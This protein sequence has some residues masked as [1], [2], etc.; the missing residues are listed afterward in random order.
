MCALGSGDGRHCW[1][2]GYGEELLQAPGPR[3]PPCLGHGE[4]AGR[5]RP[6]R[7][8][9]TR[10]EISPTPKHCKPSPGLSTCKKGLRAQR[11]QGLK[12]LCVCVCV[13]V[14]CWVGVSFSAFRDPI[15]QNVGQNKGRSRG[16]EPADAT[17]VSQLHLV[18]RRPPCGGAY[19]DPNTA[20]LP[21]SLAPELGVQ[22]YF[23]EFSSHS[24]EARASHPGPM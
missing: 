23:P 3:P 10:N 9:G 15:P 1:G 6:P 4:G 13:R 21:G 14:W 11:C 20:R 12:I 8:A 19:R 2:G 7:G 17:C 5:P 16:G 22:R 18:L 24:R